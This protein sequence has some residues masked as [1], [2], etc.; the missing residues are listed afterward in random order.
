MALEGAQN[1]T[2]TQPS[3]CVFF[4]GVWSF[5]LGDR[6]NT[7][8]FENLVEQAKTRKDALVLL[9]RLSS[10]SEEDYRQNI[11]YASKDASTSSL[12]RRKPGGFDPCDP[13]I[14]RYTAREA[15][16]KIDVSLWI[17]KIERG[18]PAEIKE[19]IE[20][21]SSLQRTEHPQAKTMFDYLSL[22]HLANKASEASLEEMKTALECLFQLAEPVNHSD[23][24]QILGDLPLD[25][26][27]KFANQGTAE[28]QKVALHFLERLESITQRGIT[29]LI[30]NTQAWRSKE[31]ELEKIRV[32]TQKNRSI[33][34]SRGWGFNFQP[35][36]YRRLG[37]QNIPWNPSLQFFIYDQP[38]AGAQPLWGIGIGGEF[39][40]GG[41]SNLVAGGGILSLK[42]VQPVPYF[43]SYA[44]SLNAHL[45]GGNLG[46]GVKHLLVLDATVE[47]RLLIMGVLIG[48]GVA[49]NNFSEPVPTFKVALDFGVP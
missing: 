32:E 19:A 11:L 40:Y 12:F 42:Y 34:D 5:F 29:G 2:A 17:Q 9:I 27:F 1:N 10:L 15:L 38:P 43:F 23:A 48:G 37:S 45:G 35:A 30:R 33:F 26:W 16:K 44:F 18:S 21:L 31:A 13:E 7:S 24:L 14:I 39:L 6:F 28:E 3:A 41:N 22:S 25:Q 49:L 8:F 20:T 47:G 46:E 36:A 4:N